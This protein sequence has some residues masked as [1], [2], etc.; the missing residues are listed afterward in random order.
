M[1]LK[2]IA[3]YASRMAMTYNEPRISARVVQK[4]LESKER[5]ARIRGTAFTIDGDIVQEVVKA[6]QK[7]AVSQL[8]KL[9]VIFPL[10]PRQVCFATLRKS[11]PI[12]SSAHVMG[13]NS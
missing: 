10:C 11:W 4:V 6:V 5:G 7:G 8:P 3:N 12:K 2:L 13:R 9:L 1:R